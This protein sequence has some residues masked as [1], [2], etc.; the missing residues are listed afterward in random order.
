VPACLGHGVRRAGWQVELTSVAQH[1]PLQ[2][3]RQ[4][5]PKRET[6]LTL[7]EPLTVEISADTAI[8]GGT[9]RHAARFVRARPE[10]GPRDIG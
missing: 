7:V 2:H 8:V 1:D 5:R 10:V 6:Q 4:V 3:L 9:I